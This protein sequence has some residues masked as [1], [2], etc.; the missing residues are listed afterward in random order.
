MGKGG[1]DLKSAITV[2]ASLFP[3]RSTPHKPR[4]PSANHESIDVFAGVP[5]RRC[6]N[7]RSRDRRGGQEYAGRV[8]SQPCPVPDPVLLRRLLVSPHAPTP[9]QRGSLAPLFFF[10]ILAP[11]GLTQ[12]GPQLDFPGTYVLFREDCHESFL[13]P[14]NLFSAATLPTRAIGSAPANPSCSITGAA[15]RPMRPSAVSF[16]PFLP[17]FSCIYLPV[18]PSITGHFSVVDFVRKWQHTPT[19]S[20]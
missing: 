14:A 20:S 2:R 19:P 13:N 5:R 16:H 17:S 15:A 11:R 4:R 7:L 18:F 8:A 10:F 6:R 1:A 12:S 3:I 9:P